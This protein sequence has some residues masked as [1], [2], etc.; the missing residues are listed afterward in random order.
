M[1]PMQDALKPSICEFPEATGNLFVIMKLLIDFYTQ[2]E[3]HVDNYICLCEY[4]VY[5]ALWL[6]AL[7]LSIF[8]NTIPNSF[9][10][11]TLQGN[12]KTGFLSYVMMLLFQQR[13]LSSVD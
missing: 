9:K 11:T 12:M 5:Q 8:L 10:L 1:H 3:V 6:N 2:I 13:G 7:S 4:F